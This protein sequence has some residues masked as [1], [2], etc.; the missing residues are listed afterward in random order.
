[1]TP[2]KVPTSRSIVYSFVFAGFTTILGFLGLW[3]MKLPAP[4]LDNSL[5]LSPLSQ[6]RLDLS[7]KN[8]NGLEPK[9]LESLSKMLLRR[10]PR[11]SLSRLALSSI[12]INKGEFKAM[13]NILAPLPIMRPRRSDVYTRSFALR[14]HNDNVFD[15]WKSKIERDKPVWGG[16][17]LLYLFTETN[18]DL[19]QYI[20]LFSIY[21]EKHPTLYFELL[22]RHG[23]EKAYA[24]FQK[25]SKPSEPNEESEIVQNSKFVRN[26]S[27]W[28]F[29]WR[30]NPAIADIELKGGA[31]IT[32]SGRETPKVMEQVVKV[33][34]GSYGLSI[35]MTGNIP[36]S[37]G[38][39][40]IRL[41]C[42]RGPLILDEP[43]EGSFTAQNPFVLKFE[44]NEPNCE[45]VNLSLYGSPGEFPAP[46]RVNIKKLSIVPI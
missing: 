14:S 22:K 6:G 11:S 4:T 23:P 7:L 34:K 37:K 41:K 13:E 43:I 40:R 27:R 31:F 33:E 42:W 26:G 28:P 29:G 35:E 46:V 8:R 25:L 45:F 10:N 39:M 16:K 19:N 5:Y 1:M 38:H 12:Y 9:Q 32:Y 21:P 24:A 17:Y 44:K 30:L 20:H 2:D 18:R 3:Y 36:R 15:I